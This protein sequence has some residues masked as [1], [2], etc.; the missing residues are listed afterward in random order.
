VRRAVGERAVPWA[1]LGE[2]RVQ[3]EFNRPAGHRDAGLVF[4]GPAEG[5]RDDGLDDEPDEIDPDEIDTD[6]ID[7]LDEDAL[8][9]RDPAGSGGE[10]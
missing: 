6:E 3:V 1:E 4:T 10:Q 7:E 9:Q 2:G 8:D 5:E